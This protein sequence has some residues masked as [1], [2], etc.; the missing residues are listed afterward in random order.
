[1]YMTLLD[2]FE[3]DASLGLHCICACVCSSALV[4]EQMAI[5]VWL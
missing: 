2:V 3:V 5:G 4:A 1:M